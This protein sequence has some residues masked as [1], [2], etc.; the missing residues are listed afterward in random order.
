[1]PQLLR[2]RNVSTRIILQ[3]PRDPRNPRRVVNEW[4]HRSADCM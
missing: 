1:M 2:K 4:Q 3:S